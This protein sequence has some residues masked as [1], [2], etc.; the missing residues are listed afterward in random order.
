MNQSSKPAETKEKKPEAHAEPPK[1]ESK[2]V[3]APK[4]EKKHS[5]KQNYPL[6]K[7]EWKNE[8]AHEEKPAL[9]K[10]QKKSKTAQKH[11]KSHHHHHSHG[12]HG[13]SFVQ[14]GTQM[15]VHTRH[16]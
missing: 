4:K 7:I 8:A 16:K 9:A 10:T 14:T 11:H 12:S 15:N 2:P 6:P 1:S 13:K 5:K 3:D